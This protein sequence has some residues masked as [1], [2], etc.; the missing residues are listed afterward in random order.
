MTAATDDLDEDARSGI[1]APDTAEAVLL[2]GEK[3]RK[4]AVMVEDLMEISPFDADAAVLPWVVRANLSCS[5]R[6]ELTEVTGDRGL[7]DGT[8][9]ESC[10]ASRPPKAAGSSIVRQPDSIRAGAGHFIRPGALHFAP[11]PQSPHQLD[12]I[13]ETHSTRA[14]G[15]SSAAGQEINS[16]AV[17]VSW[18]V[19]HLPRRDGSLVRRVRIGRHPIRGR[20]ERHR[21]PCYTY[22]EWTKGRGREVGVFKKFLNYAR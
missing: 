15:R 17:P 10:G 20:T 14:W 7:C 1:T 11:T 22:Q 4:L 3:T 2:I 16:A 6:H 19:E 8:R 9:A 18:D 12:T 5:G 21:F 13:I